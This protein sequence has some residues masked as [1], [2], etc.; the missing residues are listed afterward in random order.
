MPV[1]LYHL[2]FVANVNFNV[3]FY[4][5]KK[6]A[7]NILFRWKSDKLPP[8]GVMFCLY[9]KIILNSFFLFFRREKKVKSVQSNRIRRL[10]KA[11]EVF[12]KG[13]PEGA[14]E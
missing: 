9:K 8:L 14:I 10:E 2:L 3:K 12:V 13:I 1:F 6:L 4:A 7:E 11:T 5:K